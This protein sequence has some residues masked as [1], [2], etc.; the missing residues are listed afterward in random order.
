[1]KKL[2]ALAGI[3]MI[4][5]ACDRN[6]GLKVPEADSM[7]DTPVTVNAGVAEMMTRAGHDAGEL[8]SGSLGLFI[9]TADALIDSRY[10]A[11]NREVK[12]E[13]NHWKIQGN[14]LLWRNESSTVEYIA[15]HP[16]TATADQ[17]MPT[18]TIPV[19]QTADNVVDFLYVSGTTS[20]QDSPDGINLI[21]KH[22]M[23]KLTV[24]LRGGTELGDTPEFKQVAIKRM[25]YSAPFDFMTKVW[26]IS[27][28]DISD[29]IMIQNSNETYEA[30]VIPQTMS[31]LVVEITTG[32]DRTFRYA[33]NNVTFASGMAYTLDLLVGKDKVEI[34]DDGI[35]VDNWG[36]E[37]N[38][39]DDFVTE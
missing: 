29:V 33:Q 9:T 26:D 18:I 15:Y 21:M 38:F 27:E 24:T 1:M 8:K 39:E 14:K 23:S 16:Y 4:I 19:N 35:A 11:D 36:S 20:G 37:N 17:M 34:V 7:T 25:K 12:Y 30:I 10:N 5:A 32:D 2:F 6:D 31:E 28:S 22:K 13:N 3:A